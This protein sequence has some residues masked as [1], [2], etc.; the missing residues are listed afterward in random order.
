MRLRFIAA[1]LAFF[2]AAPC[3]AQLALTGIGPANS[4]VVQP[5]VLPGT[6]LAVFSSIRLTGWNGKYI[7]IQRADTTQT[8]IGFVGNI[9]DCQAAITFGGG[10]PV[11][12]AKWYDQS[13]NGNDMPQPTTAN[14]PSFS[15]TTFVNGICPVVFDGYYNNYNGLPPRSLNIPAALAPNVNS[16]SVLMA[17]R[18]VISYETQAWWEF[19]NAGTTYFSV[20][21]FNAAPF[22]GGVNTNNN[23]LF[24]EATSRV[25]GQMTTLAVTSGAVTQNIIP[26]GVSTAQ[27]GPSSQV[28]N[29]GGQVGASIAGAVYNLQGDIFAMVVYGSQLNTTD[30]NTVLGAFNSAFSIPQTFTTRLVYGGSSLISGL[31]STYNQNVTRLIG[32]PSNVEIYNF[33]NSAGQ[34]LAQECSGTANSDE[35]AMYDGTKAS[36]IFVVDA[37]SNGI[38]NQAA[39][40]NAA[41]AIAFA[42][43]QYT[44]VF[45]PCV[46]ARLGAGVKAHVVAPTIISRAGF[47]TTTNFYE[48]ARVRYNANIVAGAG[49][50]GYSVADRAANANIGCALCYLNA[51]YFYTDG[52]HL[53]DTGYAVMAPI[54]GGAISPLV[55]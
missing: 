50:N 15:A 41:A 39:F 30:T 53:N 21:N 32:L 34:T 45:L 37:D 48:N 5:L 8:D 10:S 47:D 55:H 40:A 44:T 17:V 4:G 6:P 24:N 11:T 51:V 20:F 22:N 16:F 25:R 7:R 36:V 52:V 29:A 23:G 43:N 54:D 12:I 1:L 42:D 31:G 14:Q 38:A 33:G 26:N 19:T 3:P 49:A 28:M 27:T 18:Q 9:P 2:M 13:G 46:A 35:L